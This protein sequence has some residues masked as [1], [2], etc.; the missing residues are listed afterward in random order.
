[1]PAFL[2]PATPEDQAAIHALMVGVIKASVDEPH[3]SG[4]IE[5]V[6]KNLQVWHSDP[7]TC[8]HIVAQKGDEIVGVILVKEF[9]NLCSLFVSQEYQ[10]QGIGRDLVVAAIVGCRFRSPKQAIYLNSSPRAIPF[11]SSLG[12]VP[13]ESIQP[14]PQEFK[15]MRLVRAASEA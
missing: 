11:Y 14:L 8:L 13:R 4:T 5:N 6:T 10:R 1:M 9:W 2:R 7:E 3:Q 15:P 12:F